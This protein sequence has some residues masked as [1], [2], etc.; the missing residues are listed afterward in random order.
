MGEQAVR[1]FVMS[2][3]CRAMNV[4]TKLLDALDLHK[5]AHRKEPLLIQLSTDQVCCTASMPACVRCI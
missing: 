2:V 4:P 3:L 1:L 5:L